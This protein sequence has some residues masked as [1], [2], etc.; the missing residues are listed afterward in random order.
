MAGVYRYN[1]PE[2]SATAERINKK[3]QEFHTA[4][5]AVDNIV[6]L[7]NRSWNDTVNLKFTASYLNVAKPKAEELDV[8]IKQYAALLYQSASRFGSA[9]DGGNSYLTGF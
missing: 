5:V 3:Y 8:L 4:R 9:I 1:P 2:M 7:M 6:S